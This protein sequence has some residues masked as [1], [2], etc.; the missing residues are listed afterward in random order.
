MCREHDLS[1]IL[2]TQYLTITSYY[3]DAATIMEDARPGLY[4]NNESQLSLAKYFY[5]LAFGYQTYSLQ[6]YIRNVAIYT[7]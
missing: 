2:S 1:T 7:V 3:Q 6:Q 5:L 4:K